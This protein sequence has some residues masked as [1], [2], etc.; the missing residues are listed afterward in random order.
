MRWNS[1]CEQA[2][3][4][5]RTSEQNNDFTSVNF[6]RLKIKSQKLTKVV[7]HGMDAITTDYF[8]PGY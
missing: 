4:D 7:F 6:L 8:N 1:V 2:L 5:Q 3:D